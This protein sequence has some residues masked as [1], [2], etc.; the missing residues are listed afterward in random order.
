[1]NDHPRTRLPLPW[2]LAVLAALAF[3]AG[4]APA[5]APLH[6]A[7]PLAAMRWR[8]VGPYGNRAAAIAGVAGNP[9]VDYVGAAAGGIWKTENGGVDWRPVFDHENV[10]AIGALAVSES[11]PDVVWAGTGETFLIRPFYPM[12]NG[13]YKSTDAGEHWQHMG[14]D[15]TGH[16]GRIVIDPHDAQRVFVCALG[17]AF[18]P[19]PNRGVYRTTDGGK[20]WEH[21]LA[22][23]VNTGCSDLAIDPQDPNTLFAGMWP[24]LVR[25]WNLNSGGPTGGVYVTHD[26]GTTWHKIVGHGLPAAD[27]PIGKVAV[28]IAHSDPRVVYALLQDS[29]PSLY[30]SSDGGETWTLVSHD[31]MMMQRDS[32]YVR[33]GVSTA[34]PDRLYFLSPN[35]TISPDGGKT[36]LLPG[37]R[38]RGGANDFASAGGDNHDMWIDPTNA[39]RIMV[40]NDAGAQLSLDGSRSF[41]HIRLPI[42]QVYHVSVDDQ[43][44]YNIYGNLQDA[45]SFFGPSNTLSGGFFGGGITASDFRPVGGC[46]SGFA[47]PDPSDN[48]IVWSGCYEGVITRVN[49]KDGQVRDV[50]VWPD[51]A[52]GWPP[53]DVKERWHWTIP[54]EI[55]PF[56][57]KRVYVGSQYVHETTDGGQT[58]KT[59]SP[60]L[61]LND[62]SHQGN[63]GG[64]THD[65]LYTY[66]GDV[67]YSIAESPKRQGLIWVGTND[68][69]VQLTKDGG[70]TWTNVTRNIPNLPPYG[71]IWNIEPS[72]FDPATAYITVNRQQMGDYGAYVY[73]TSDYGQSWRFISGGVP[74]SFNSSAHCVIEDPVRPGMLYLGTDNAVY[75]SWDDGGH[76]THLNNN[77]PAA[78]VYWL[79]VQRRFNDL[80]ISTYGRGDY[81][82]DD[83][84]AL[85]NFDRVENANAVHLFPPRPAYRFRRRGDTP[86]SEPGVR[87]IG[88]NPPY[89]A[90]INFYLP[91][92]DSSVTVAIAD[93]NGRTVRTLNAH[94]REGLNRVWWDLRGENGKM[95]HLLVPPPGAPWVRNN[96]DGYR[97]VTGIMIPS[98]VRGPLMIPGRYTVRL[99]AGGHT[100][101][102]ALTVLPDPHSLGSAQTLAAGLRFHQ[103]VI[104]EIDSVSD[105]IE[106]LEQAR[107]RAAA[108]EE[109]AGTDRSPQ[110]VV[111]AAHRLADSATAIESKLIDIYLT[112]GNEDLNRHPSQ[113]YQKLTA[114]YDKDQADLGPTAAEVE[115]NAYFRQWM[116]RS[117]A[118]LDK[119]LATDVPAFDGVMRSHHMSLIP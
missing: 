100:Q 64:I 31:H 13:V 49:L 55:S 66:D 106:R 92:A 99:T 74:T 41:E 88:Q 104:G 89:G 119:F 98:Q 38:G 118:A 4:A 67:I 102:A 97:I 52:D 35:Y 73:K 42:A 37:R 45:S 50:S 1:M 27:H 10:Q 18:T 19:E 114:L 103:Q 116:A 111:Q 59:I 39:N 75:V 48:D 7:N 70:A 105:M 96:R 5:Q 77:L 58:W 72:H 36:F 15:S 46:E 56:D 110:A 26:G 82:L 63:S 14:L 108:V 6:G 2:A 9:M 22:V 20:T 24:L 87:V 90:D 54:L 84:T 94:G 43:I 12:G 25:P 21:V 78:P 44:P 101:A 32:Y 61:T 33:F 107:E 80:V 16:V 81:I 51:V 68:G 8:F 11:D 3:G 71:T 113:L 30:R 112:D 62:K 95:P 23:D 83:V 117:Q 34:D 86:L 28:A 79:V 65:N 93:G 109:R 115:V 57:P 76:W 47:T 85:R 17:Q 60:D 69:Q 29:E 91:A 40:A 53:K